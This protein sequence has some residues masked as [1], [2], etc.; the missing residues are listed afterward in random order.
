MIIEHLLPGF[1][2]AGTLG[3]RLQEL[4]AVH[5]ADAHQTQQP[6]T[7][8]EHKTLGRQLLPRF[9]SSHTHVM[10]LPE[11]TAVCRLGFAR[12][13]RSQHGSNY[14]RI[15]PPQNCAHHCSPLNLNLQ[16]TGRTGDTH[17]SGDSRPSRGH[18]QVSANLNLKALRPVHRHSL[19]QKW[20]QPARQKSSQEQAPRITGWHSNTHR[21][22]KNQPVEAALTQHVTLRP[23]PDALQQSKA[24]ATRMHAHRC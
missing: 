13:I 7:G 15:Q 14:R 21:S 22:G 6:H 17:S 19:T 12:W 2:L 5:E 8:A 24:G 4:P 20:K 23:S 18:P 9:F 10:H 16:P 11:F 1:L 3:H